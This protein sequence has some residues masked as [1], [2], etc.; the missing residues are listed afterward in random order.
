MPTVIEVEGLDDP[1][2]RDFSRRTDVGLRH[3]QK[4]EHGIY[5]AESAQ[6]ARRALRLGHSPRAALA[7]PGALDEARDVLAGHPG[8]P[9][10][11]A[12]DERLAELTG[13]HLHR[14]LVLSLDRP[15]LPSVAEVLDGARTVVII[16]N[17][18]DPTNVGAIFRSVAG[19]GADAVLV[20]E[21]CSDPFYRRAI[22]VSMA[23]TLQVPWTRMGDW[24]TTRAQLRTAGFHLAT[25]D[26]TDDAVD[27]RAFAARRP[28]RLAIVLGE[29][30]PG[31]TAEATAAADSVLTI[32][33]HH[34]VDS[35]N[36]AAASA[37][38]LWALAGAH[39]A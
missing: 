14:G 15:A 21:R 8:T 16:E 33:M 1:R 30:G 29:E 37:V 31:I 17:V 27:L 24:H 26:L 28:E 12:P 23:A 22:R 13:Y 25:L 3:D 36:V 10:F 34:G 18:A 5:L 20:T 35:L 2:L 4:T 39:P 19:I 38:A 7:L 11:T 9:I 32:P 6:V